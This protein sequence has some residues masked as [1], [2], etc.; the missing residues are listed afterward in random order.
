MFARF[1]N[2]TTL[3]L[4]DNPATTLPSGIFSSNTKLTSL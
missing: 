2:L 1:S 3:V 4:N